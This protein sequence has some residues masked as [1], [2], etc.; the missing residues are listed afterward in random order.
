MAIKFR[1]PHCQQLL[2]IST[3]KAGTIVDCP[4]CGRS[5]NVPTEGGVGKKTEPKQP[6]NKDTGL[7][8][9]LQELS[10][11]GDQSIRDGG[12]PT[13]SKSV[14]L[15]RE[16]PVARTPSSQTG[17]STGSDRNTMRIVPLTKAQSN[18]GTG[19][20]QK[21]VF[22]EL[23]GMAHLENTEP[24]ILDELPETD[25]IQPNQNDD[26]P[27]ATS[28][29]RPRPHNLSTALQELADVPDAARSSAM[30]SQKVILQSTS[31][32]SAFLP[33]IFALPAFAI[34]LL[35]GT[36]WK[37]NSPPSLLEPTPKGAAVIPAVMAPAP[38]AG[39]RQINGIVSYVDDSG[40]LVAD[41]GAIVLLL[42]SENTT[43]LRLDA[44]PLREGS[45]SKARQAIEAALDTLGGSVYQ[46]D[47][48]GQWTANVSA[49]TAFKL[50]FISRHRSRIESQPI[51]DDAL[52]SLSNW[53]DSPLHIV[54][55]L[56][57][58]Q[59]VLPPASDTHPNPTLVQ[60]EF[61]R[62]E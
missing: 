12:L 32:R 45:D 31:K 48:K 50:T 40:N 49:K 53:F 37:P 2:G 26:A 8:N 16:S 4:A 42:P 14:P 51:P 54:G 24:L 28:A 36:F 35:L 44:R 46:T 60:T 11:L 43:R 30:R 52:A 58:K 15:E 38:E 34:G 25:G 13:L 1:C 33:L 20:P 21:D 39:E 27:V 61:P 59:T 7:L 23:A 17:S 29:P 18:P 57:V 55:R 6:T 22:A 41:T 5:V 56:A 47:S 10:A 62:G 19:S 9:A 3:T